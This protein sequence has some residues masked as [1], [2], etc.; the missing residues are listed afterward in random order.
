MYSILKINNFRQFKDFEMDL[1]PISIIAGKN[2]T[3]KTSI[4][5]SIFL[6]HDYANPNVFFKISNFRGIH[7]GNITPKKVWEPIFN[8]LNPTKILTIGLDA[9]FSIKL[10]KNGRYSL[11]NDVSND[12]KSIIGT[13]SV[14]YALSCAVKKDGNEFKG[15][16]IIG[17]NIA[18]IGDNGKTPLFTISYIQY[19]GPNVI[20]DDIIITEWFGRIEL[21]EKEKK[22]ILIEGLQILD[23]NITDITTI[24]ENGFPQ[25]YITGKQKTKMPLC[26]MGDGIRKI[27]NAALTILANP[28][29]VILLD[30]LENGLHHSLHS[31]FWEFIVSLATQEKCQVIATTHSYECINGVFKGIKKLGLDDNFAYIRLDT[32]NQNVVSKTFTSD[33]LEFAL[34]SDLEVR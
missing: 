31:K 11:P 34:D 3:G 6:L 10:E 2:N 23:K 12:L 18:L 8:E 27:M 30:E 15:N 16:Y 13:P 28:A 4:L 33:M 32:E 5:E 1:K 17:N 9:D 24:V 21:M 20:P 25:L 26:I 29:C 14:N 22:Q 19:I 7:T